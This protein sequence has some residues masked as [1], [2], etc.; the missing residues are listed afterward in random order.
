MTRRRLYVGV[1]LPGFLSITLATALASHAMLEIAQSIGLLGGD[2]LRH[3]HGAVFP[4]VLIAA[5]GAFCGA[6]LY[7]AHLAELDDAS[8]PALARAL[9]ERIGWQTI[10][11]SAFGACLVL[12]VMES[13]EQLAAGRFEGVASVFGGV[14]IIGLGL[15][16]F[17][18]SVCNALALTV[19]N[20]LANAHGRLVRVVAFFLRSPRDGTTATGLPSKHAALA[21]FD[22]FFDISQTHGKRAP[23]C[24]AS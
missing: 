16:L 2:Y 10:V 23:P 22:Y 11:S 19:C 4:V 13:A 3:S 24:L 15:V 14:P 5:A 17:I 20:W 21:T 18:S 1:A 12:I 8:V 7:A 6:L 9:S